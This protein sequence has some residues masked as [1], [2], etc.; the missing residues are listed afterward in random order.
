MFADINAPR[1]Y[2]DMSAQAGTSNRDKLQKSPMFLHYTSLHGKGICQQARCFFSILSAHSVF[3]KEYDPLRFCYASQMVSHSEH[4][5]S[6]LSSFQPPC[7]KS[8][9]KKLADEQNL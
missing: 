9:S 4:F 1:H 6:A 7:N 2:L 8:R 5:L 3:H